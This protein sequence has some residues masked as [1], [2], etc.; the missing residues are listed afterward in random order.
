MDLFE[1]YK[2]QPSELRIV[3]EKYLDML[4]QGDCDAYEVCRIF[5]IEVKKLGYTFEY[6]LDGEPF[7]LRPNIVKGRL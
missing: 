5:L 6:G 4:L 2:L 1:H 7:N 3:C